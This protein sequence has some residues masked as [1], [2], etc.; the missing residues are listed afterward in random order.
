ML[1]VLGG[2][3]GGAAGVASGAG[4]GAKEVELERGPRR[5]AERA[6]ILSEG[7]PIRSRVS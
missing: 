1:E 3:E 5:P 6:N 7:I 4:V 2:G